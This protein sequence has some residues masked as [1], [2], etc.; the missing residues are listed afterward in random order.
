VVP[1]KRRTPH[2]SPTT[3]WTLLRQNDDTITG[4]TLGQTKILTK[5]GKTKNDQKFVVAES[6]HVRVTAGGEFQVEAEASDPQK[7]IKQLEGLRAQLTRLCN[8]EQQ[9]H[10]DVIMES[11]SNDM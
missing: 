7:A 5:N 9:R 1:T 6:R 2:G 8:S 10:Y 3:C 11:V 4:L